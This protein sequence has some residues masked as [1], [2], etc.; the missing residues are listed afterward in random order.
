MMRTV[1]VFIVIS[2]IAGAFVVSTFFAVLPWPRQ[3]SPVNL[4]RLSL[5][6]LE[7]MDSNYD[8]SLAAFDPT[9]ATRWAS[10]N[11]ALSASL[12]SN[13]LYNLTVYN[14][15]SNE[16]GATLYSAATSI[17]NAEDLGVSSDASSY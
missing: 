17:S 12:P 14:V 1:E 10:L 6:T 2:I 11:V 9:N 13:V 3:V 7:T 16:N 5:T 15:N 4:R 8:L